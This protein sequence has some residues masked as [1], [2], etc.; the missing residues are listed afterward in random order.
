MIKAS[1]PPKFLLEWFLKSLLPYISKD[2]STSG[3]TNEEEAIFKAWKLELIYSQSGILYEI[4]PDASRSITDPSKPKSGPHADGI[5]G[6]VQSAGTLTNQMSNLSIQSSG[7]GSA[8]V[9][10]PP[11]RTASIHTV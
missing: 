7:S 11:S 3:V 4:I 10:E 9:D 8:Q 6:S 5:V 2:V 1:I